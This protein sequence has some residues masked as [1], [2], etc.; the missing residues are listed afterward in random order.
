MSLLAKIFVVIVA[1][2][3][4]LFLGVTA[5]LYSYR[6]DW[7]TAYDLLRKRHKEVVQR[8]QA[9]IDALKAG[10]GQ[11]EKYISVKNA[12]VR[13][14]KNELDSQGDKYLEAKRSLAR[15]TMEYEYLIRIHE[16]LSGQIKEMEETITQLRARIDQQ[17]SDLDIALKDKE[18]AENQVARLTSIKNT[19]EK[20]LSTARKDLAKAQ[21]RLQEK[22]L[23]I[24]L[25]EEKG[26]PVQRLVTGSPPPPIDGVVVAVKDDIVPALVLLSVGSDDKVE[27][28]IEFTIH[29]GNKFIGKV[30]VEKVLKDMC[31]A[32]VIIPDPKGYTGLPTEQKIQEGDNASTRLQ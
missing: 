3:S 28:G 29:R 12:E 23:V 4:L 21:K 25:L 20:D 11:L 31:G 8:D 6:T 5:T 30:L 32:R 15:K 10:V 16:T 22:E 17:K 2:F 9:E 26:I 19:L 1:I 14:L 13:I 7:R 27:K 18:T 24:H